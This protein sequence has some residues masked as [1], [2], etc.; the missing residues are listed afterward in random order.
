MDVVALNIPGVQNNLSQ[1]MRRGMLRTSAGSRGSR[2]CIEVLQD[3]K[4]E[5]MDNWFWARSSQVR[6]LLMRFR[7]SIGAQKQI[8]VPRLIDNSLQVS[9][10]GD[11][12][13]IKQQFQSLF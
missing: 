12:G 13:Y 10:I 5:F 11:Q 3:E 8:S 9:H 7:S 4:R 1:L 6:K 2:G